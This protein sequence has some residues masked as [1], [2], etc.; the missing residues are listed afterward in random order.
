MKVDAI[1]QCTLG[2]AARTSR[3]AE[4][5]GFDRVL[6]AEVAHDPFLPLVLSV[7]ATKRITLG[8]GIAVA[9]ARSPMTL[10]VTAADI[11]R[12][13]RGRFVLG[14]G[15]QIKPHIT[16]RFSMPWSSPAARMREFVLA[17]RAI[18]TAWEYGTPLD[19]QGEF[20]QHTLMTPMF[21]QGPSEFG[22]PEVYV[23]GVGP[24]MTAVAGELADGV[25]VPRIHH[26]RLP[27]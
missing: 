7:P 1:V 11:H 13:S 2:D 10:A 25:H 3:E 9:F 27:A 19:F 16:R 18:W 21:D 23:A 12:F 17:L 4:N 15:S 14:L 20:Y 5:F 24:A 6:H 22:W 8:T 26:A